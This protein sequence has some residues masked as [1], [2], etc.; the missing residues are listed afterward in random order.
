MSYTLEE[1]NAS[2]A[3]WKKAL[4]ACATGKSYTIGD[5]SLTMHDLPE[6][7]KTIEWLEVKR[8]KLMGRASTVYVKPKFRR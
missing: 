4:D 2:L 1:I 5:R 8:S 3:R 7:R 6:I